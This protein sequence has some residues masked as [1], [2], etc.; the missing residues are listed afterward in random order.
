MDFCNILASHIPKR[1]S[2]LAHGESLSARYG[3]HSGIIW[4]SGYFEYD[5]ERL[6]MEDR[7]QRAT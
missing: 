7:A 3:Q 1:L 6:L 5:F 4:K 2:D